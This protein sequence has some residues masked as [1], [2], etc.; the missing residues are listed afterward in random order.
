MAASAAVTN[1]RT[2]VT[3]RGQAAPGGRQA[4][5]GVWFDTLPGPLVPRPALTGDIRCDIAIVGAGFTGLW[6]AYY[7]KK[8]EPSLAVVVVEREIAGFGASGRNGGWCHPSLPVDLETL[9][10]EAGRDMALAMPRV[11]FNTV[12]EVGRVAA[13]EGIDAHYHQGG[14]FSLATAPEQL[15]RTREEAEYWE[16]WGFGDEVRWLDAG[17]VA[18]DIRVHGCLGGTLTAHSAVVQ[19]AALVRGLAD[20]AERH[21][22]TIHEGSLVR[23]FGPRT[24]RTAAGTIHA[25]YVVRATEG[26]TTGFSGQH[27]RFIPIYSLMIATEPLPDEIWKQIGWSSRATFGD[28]RHLYIYAAR[29]PDGRIAIG[30]RGAPYHYGSSVRPDFETVPEVFEKLRRV[31]VGFFP[32]LADVRITHQ[33]GGP[34]AIPRDWHPSVGLDRATGIA[35]AGGYVGDGVATSNLCGR[36]LADLLLERQTD[37][38]HLPL[39]GHCSPLW[40]PEPLRW[41]G[42]H[43]SMGLLAAADRRE[44]R[45]GRPAAWAAVVKRVLGV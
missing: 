31:L 45:T 13:E 32:M 33:W 44:A 7:L 34:L 36:I 30:G 18:E 6:T 37:L 12:D 21:G 38:A 19:P 15:R 29:T 14:M 5:P 41:L 17:E 2:V 43:A 8:A 35:W 23:E 4:P 26:Y 10:R 1:Q 20:A 16:R 24:V 11:M 28:G 22:V 3:S 42:V 27:R 25:D 39:V 40:E 9:E